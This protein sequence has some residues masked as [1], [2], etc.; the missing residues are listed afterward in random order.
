MATINAAELLKHDKDLG[1]ITVGK[2]A[3]IVT[4][5]GDPTKDINLMSKVGFVMKAGKVY[6]LDGKEVLF[7]SNNH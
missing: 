7:D 6:K 1:S 2:Y 5:P 3:D 4:V